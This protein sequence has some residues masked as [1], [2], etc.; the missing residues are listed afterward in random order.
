MTARPVPVYA[1]HER[2]PRR[3]GRAA[4][5]WRVFRRRQWPFLLLAAGFVGVMVFTVSVI[6]VAA[7]MRGWAS[8]GL[9]IS[10]LLCAR[11]LRSA[12][13]GWRTYLDLPGDRS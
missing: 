4:R 1:A 12:P 8:L 7:H 11:G 9:L 10:A 6:E 5:H 3:P 13:G 2:A